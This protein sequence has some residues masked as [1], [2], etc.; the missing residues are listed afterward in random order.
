MSHPIRPHY[1]SLIL[2]VGVL[3]GGCSRP[4]ANVDSTN[5][6]V[7]KTT[8]API[9]AEV[10]PESVVENEDWEE[11]SETVDGKKFK[12]A[13]LHAIQR[14]DRIVVKEHAD[15]PDFWDEEAE[16]LVGVREILYGEKTL[17]ATQKE[18]LLKTTQSMDDATQMM[19][20]FCGPVWHHSIEFYSGEDLDSRMQICFE[21]YQISWEGSRH[22]PPGAIYKS[23]TAFIE[24]LGFSAKRD[25][26][27]L[28]KT[29]P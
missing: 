24:T 7:K 19:F 8:D 28:A 6:T 20:A 17:D 21:C 25:W 2:S 26:K 27:T 18:S 12:D 11:V 5:D 23:L 9:F 4:A 29:S 10:K 22:T 15:K 1:F 16:Q 13:F 14:A 3:L